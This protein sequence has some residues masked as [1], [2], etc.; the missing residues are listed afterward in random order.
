MLMATYWPPTPAP[1]W[2][3]S[4]SFVSNYF[5][6]KFG[7]QYC[8]AAPGTSVASIEILKVFEIPM[9][10]ISITIPFESPLIICIMFSGLI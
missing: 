8:V 5:I 2:R 3:R 6:R 7:N 1:N 10:I 9:T 4:M